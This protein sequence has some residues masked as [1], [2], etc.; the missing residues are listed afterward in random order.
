MNRDYD[1]TPPHLLG[2]ARDWYELASANLSNP[3][4]DFT[5][6]RYV[7]F[8][9]SLEFLLKAL[10]CINKQ[11]AQKSVLQKYSH[12]LGKTKHAAL[13]EVSDKQIITMINDFFDKYPEF[14]NIDVIE[15]RYGTLGSFNT[16]DAGALTDR[17]Y[18]D[19]L[20]KANEVIHREWTR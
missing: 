12:S 16:Y 9:F 2:R 20:K 5:I 17:D 6:A 7:A 14:N 15:V 11:N 1:A 3:T 8:C 18:V 4:Q 10:L 19:I 13:G